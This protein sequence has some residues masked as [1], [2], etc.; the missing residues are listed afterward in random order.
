[1]PKMIQV[2][3]VD[4]E[5]HRVLRMRAALEWM[6]LSDYIKRDLEVSAKQPTVGELAAQI[7]S[8]GTSGMTAASIVAAVREARGE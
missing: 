2:R 3:N 6:S 5:V 4:D 7:G 8:R 1:M